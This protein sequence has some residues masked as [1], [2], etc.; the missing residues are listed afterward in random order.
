MGYK[1]I[2]QLAHFRNENFQPEN[3]FKEV[4]NTNFTKQY[5]PSCVIYIL[6]WRI[7]RLY[8]RQFCPLE[9]FQM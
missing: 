2:K 3:L 9:Y 1:P 6:F 5:L 8:K 7:I 4:S